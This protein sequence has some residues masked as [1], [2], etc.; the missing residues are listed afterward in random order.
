MQR[1]PE[2]GREGWEGRR[3]I[4]G[5]PRD[6]AGDPLEELALCSGRVADN[7]DVEVAAEVDPFLGPLVH[8]SEEHQQDALQVRKERHCLRH[9][10]SG[11][12]G[13]KQCLT[14]LISSC[15]KTCG[16]TLR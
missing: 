10:I 6:K 14:F 16:A 11:N 9:E 1:G 5:A 7:A 4:C 15:P 8:A 12:T 2:R 3:E 13:Q